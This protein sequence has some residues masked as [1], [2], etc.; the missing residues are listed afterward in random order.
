MLQWPIFFA[1]YTVCAV[2]VL[3]AATLSLSLPLTYLT[4]FHKPTRGILY[5]LIF[6]LYI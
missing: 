1:R 6:P 3:F 4:S 2:K 5:P